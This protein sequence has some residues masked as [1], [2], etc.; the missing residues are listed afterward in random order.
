MRAMKGL[1]LGTAAGFAA[2]ASAQAADLPVKARPVEYVKV[3]NQYGAG[4]FY[5]PGTDTCLKIGAYIRTQHAYGNLASINGAENFTASGTRSPLGTGVA[6]GGAQ[7]FYSY[8]DRILLTTDWRTQSDYGVIR[9]YAAILANQG[10]RDNQPTW[11][12]A[13]VGGVL[14][15]FIQFAGFTIGHAVSYFDFTAYNNYGY[16]PPMTASTGVNG[17]DVVAYTAQLGNGWSASID[18]EDGQS[19]QGRA[20]NEYS[21]GDPVGPAWST[22]SVAEAAWSPDVA[23]NIRVDQQWGSAQISGALHNA[24]AGYYTT[25]PGGGIPGGLTVS[26]HPGDT[27][28][29][30]VQ[31]AL[32]LTNFLMPKDTIEGSIGYSSAATGYTTGVGG[33]QLYG[34]GNSVAVASAPDTLF[35][36]GGS[37][38]AINAWHIDGAYEHVWNPQWA[39]SVFAEYVGINY[40]SGAKNIVSAG[41]AAGTL[42][43]AGSV[44]TNCNPDWSMYQVSTRTRWNPRPELEIGLDLIW[45]HTNT[46]FSGSTV[47][48]PTTGARPAGPYAVED[49]DK[50]MAILRLV[51]NILP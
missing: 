5:V 14:R 17:I 8:Q 2:F 35:T 26:G 1:L 48:L 51:K 43:A 19:G 46:A 34:S 40:S 29:W 39:T 32:R 6:P 23:G 10:T 22:A 25:S 3:C 13:G 36:T 45:L 37:Q 11:S 30:A 18:L 7:D 50:Y 21:F 33:V 27:W 42:F 4:F 15:A 12:S 16:L 9:A 31:G 44:V 49:Q 28:G 24:S 20:H 38:E 41:C 47:V